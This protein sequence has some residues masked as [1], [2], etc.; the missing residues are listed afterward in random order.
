MPTRP[1]AARGPEG[2]TVSQWPDYTCAGGGSPTDFSRAANAMAARVPMFGV[3]A[4]NARASMAFRLLV[5]FIATLDWS[6]PWS[7]QAHPFHLVRRREKRVEPC[8]VQDRREEGVDGRA[9]PTPAARPSLKDYG[10]KRSPVEIEQ[11]EEDGEDE[12]SSSIARM[13]PAAE[14]SRN[15][16]RR[17]VSACLACRISGTPRVLGKPVCR[18]VCHPACRFR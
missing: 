11:G 8:G 13:G 1:N 4:S 10:A 18:P 15:R 2:Q 16:C 17:P 6:S 12:L 3:G 7:V 9:K 5:P 14:R